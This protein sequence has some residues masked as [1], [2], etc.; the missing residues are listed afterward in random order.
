VKAVQPQI[1][2]SKLLI[3]IWPPAL[4]LLACG[5]YLVSENWIVAV[6]VGCLGI[7]F[8]LEWVE[9]LRKTAFAA[10]EVQREWKTYLDRYGCATGSFTT[11]VR[12]Y[13]GTGHIAG[14]PVDMNVRGDAAA[15]NIQIASDP[16]RELR[17]PWAQVV[18]VSERNRRRS[19]ARRVQIRGRG[20]ACSVLEIPWSRELAH[21]V[22]LR[23]GSHS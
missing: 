10:S 3:A 19:G 6:S 15:L 4:F 5:V 22:E 11:D 16:E 18:W 23:E 12:M 9:R 8:Y 7:S 14:I 13:A 17:I 2:R 20:I 1:R 21:L